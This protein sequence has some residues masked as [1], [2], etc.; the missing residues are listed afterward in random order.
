MIRLVVT[1]SECTGKTTLAA[2]LAERYRTAWVPE[3]ARA[4]A[5]LQLRELTAADVEPIARGQL[6]AEEEGA[7][8]LRGLAARPATLSGGAGAGTPS[9][10][11]LDTD[12]ASTLAYARHYYGACPEW[13]ARQA[14]ERR[15]DLYLL[16]APDVPWLPEPGLRD[17]GHLREHMHEL[18]R[19]TLAELG[20]RVVEI[21][22]G[23]EERE[24]RAQRAIDDL[25][26]GREL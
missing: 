8:R 6:A 10:L 9:L 21:R 14:R 4:Y 2:R 15:A 17:R 26:A 19:F 7:R 16:C 20:A 12:L 13:I 3:C 5:E 1:G 18:F 11:F 23:W 22:G 24:A 25:L